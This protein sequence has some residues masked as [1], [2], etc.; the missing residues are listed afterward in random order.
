M[1]IN[2][3]SF[4]T[5]YLNRKTEIRDEIFLSRS[6]SFCTIGNIS[7]LLVTYELNCCKFQICSLETTVLNSVH[8]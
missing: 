5:R 2:G 7:D 8:L 3:L 1:T 4:S 6:T